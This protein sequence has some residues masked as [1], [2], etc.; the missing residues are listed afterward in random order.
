MEPVSLSPFLS[1]CRGKPRPRGRRVYFSPEKKPAV[2]R[3]GKEIRSILIIGE[4]SRETASRVS[5]SLV[6]RVLRVQV[7]GLRLRLR[8]REVS[9]Y[10]RLKSARLEAPLFVQISATA[11]TRI[12]L[13]GCCATRQYDVLSREN[14]REKRAK[15]TQ[16]GPSLRSSR[17]VA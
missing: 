17:R 1:S 5:L 16:R 8:T 14:S 6:P 3:R 9:V 10:A 11:D 13:L 2:S 15:S 12:Y 7:P 4:S